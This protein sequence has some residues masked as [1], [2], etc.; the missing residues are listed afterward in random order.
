MNTPLTIGSTVRT[1]G[2]RFSVVDVESLPGQPSIPLLR[3]TLKALEGEIRGQEISVLHPI[4]EVEPEEISDLALEKS[5][6]LARF[7]LL[8]D[9]F[10]LELSPPYDVL[11]SARRSRINLE[12]YQYVPALRALELPR[13]RLL[14]ADDVGL[15]KTVEAG[16]I[17]KDL[18]ARRRAN[19]VLIV[20]PAGIMDQWQKE[21][22]GK[23]GFKFTVFD[24]DTIHEIRKKI[25]FGA[26]PWMAVHRV[27]ASMDFI[28]RREGA[29]RELS[30]TKWDVV[31]V[32]EAHHFS[33][34][35]SE[36]DITDRYRLGR[37]LSEATDALLLLTATP[38]D[39]YDESFVSLLGLLEPSL[40]VPGEGL[41][42]EHY[43]RYVVRRLKRHIKKEDG[44]P[45]FLQRQ[46]IPVPVHLTLSEAALHAAVLSQARE[47]EDFAS[48]VRLRLDAEAIRLV[49]TILRKR[50]ASSQHALAETLERRRLNLTERIEDLELQRDHVRALRR[51]E[52]IPDEA[53]NRLEHD[54][55]KSYLAIMRRL[56][57]RVPEDRR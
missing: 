3:L 44:T 27:I 13:P 57:S 48:R 49:A 30:S 38:H 5:G 8:H 37:W 10:S 55:H 40:V 22:K 26:N 4:E 12:P 16:L 24:K 23:F 6:R 19:R 42:F 18:T 50:A 14:L 28:K 9:V 56:G 51:G 1:R 29:F 41:R 36:D 33:T 39:G 46:V 17:L 54:A 45:K 43:Q 7:R 34:G 53:L 31:I 15:G 21:L 52:A 35:R 25:E 20:T 2:E 47:L 32:D 11:I